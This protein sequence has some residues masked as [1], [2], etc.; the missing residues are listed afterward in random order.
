MATKSFLK[1]FVISDPKLAHKFVDSLSASF[2]KTETS[3]HKQTELSRPCSELKGD[4][5]KEFFGVK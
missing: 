1:D 2:E 3:P 4:E 5:I